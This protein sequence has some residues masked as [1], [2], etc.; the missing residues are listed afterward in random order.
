MVR[1]VPTAAAGVHAFVISGRLTQADYQDVLLPPIRDTIERR[2][3]IK[4]LAVIE[5]FD[6]LEAGGLL[7]ELKAAGKLGS[8]QDA[9]KSYFAVVTDIG[10]V[11]RSVTLFGWLVPGEL[12]V[13]KTAE[14]AGAETWLTTA[15]A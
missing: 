12:R 6:G 8:S 15:P 2:E 1:V 3:P 13:F 14:R 7:E 5:G 11:R 10:W 9:L 4:V